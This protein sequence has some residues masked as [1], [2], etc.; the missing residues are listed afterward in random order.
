MATGA[1]IARILTQYSD[2]GSKAAQKDIAR[3]TKKFDDFGK[4]ARKSFA[5]AI[6]ATAAL[7]VK[8]GTDAV[9]AAIDDAKSQVVLANALKSVTD[10]SGKLN[11]Q[12]ESY[13]KTTMFRVNVADEQLRA[14]LATLIISTGDLTK[15]EK[16]QTIALDVA[17]ATG[18]DLSAVTVAMTKANEGNVDALKR[19]SPELSG[20]IYKGMKAEDAFALLGVTY[21]GTAEALADL[22]P[23]T[24][25]RLAYGETLETLGTALLPVI[26]EFAE[27][28]ISDVI[29][30]VDE[31]V[32]ANGDKLQTAIRD[33]ADGIIYF[34]GVFKDLA[35]FLS[36]NRV[37]ITVALNLFAIGRGAK[38]A[39][40]FLT[41]I[42]ELI[43]SGIKYFKSFGKATDN[44]KKKFFDL[45]KTDK[46]G[47]FGRFVH[48]LG[49]GIEGISKFLGG[50]V[51]LGAAGIAVTKAFKSLF[52]IEEKRKDQLFD[53]T[54][55]TYGGAA[56]EKYKA[57]VVAAAAKK[58]AAA[59]AIAAAASK[60]AAAQEAKDAA[61]QAKVDSRV[62]AIR[63]SLNITKDSAL[64]K[65]TDLIS[66]TAAA[67]FLAKQGVIAK[68]ELAKIDRL[69]EENLLLSARDTLIKRYADIQEKLAD[70]KLET[71]EIEELSKKWG[72]SGAAVVAYIHLVKSVEDQVISTEEI[73]TL[74]DLWNTSEY[75]A[76]KF[77][78]TYMRIQDGL[79]DSNEVFALIKAGFF[80]TEREARTYADI[81]STVHDG[82]ANDED[83]QKVMDKWDLTKE[84]L[85]QYILKMGADFDYE[86]KL[87]YPITQL[88][89]KWDA[90]SGA[91]QRYLDKLNS[92]KSFDYNKLGPSGTPII[93]PKPGDPT[94]TPKAGDPATGDDSIAKRAAASAAAAAAYAAAKARGDMDAAAKA[95]AGVNPSALAAGE[96]GAIGAASI[97]SQLRA[98]EAA[99][100]TAT[101]QGNTLTRFR[102]KE[103][104]DL[105][106]SLAASSQLDADERSK[107]R[108]MT[109][110]NASSI[111]GDTSG[112]AKSLNVTVNISGN[113]TTEQD[114]VT[115]IRNGL[116]NSQY[117]GDAITLQAI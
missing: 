106:A 98:A 90:A 31:W 87:L 107:F 64:D 111:S 52:G 21:A 14:S 82:I 95:A 27:Y 1:V 108:S 65:E 15:A 68:E 71:K 110:A 114:L 37:L 75:E 112:N 45:V 29:P 81:V 91:L 13:I 28:I 109:M 16:L 97:A 67:N 26:K 32:A 73:K 35:K 62:L 84:K 76:Q 104:E 85:N 89:I 5:L 58:T 23:L 92:A 30:A 77:L 83:F 69:K 54:K 43:G 79:L 44:L 24:K 33:I 99:L 102:A 101:A 53:I 93:T 3:L 56:A 38:I 94:V 61:Y 60:K 63:K 46:D 4:R 96:S 39:G 117:N 105:A 51:A 50:F 115:S 113:V 72:I 49:T 70:Q 86:G 42:D 18:K 11:A 34:S 59:Q 36:D 47:S 78:E 103:A 8:I 2:K 19:L 48:L 40:K 10:A 88:A 80:E 20:L 100:A 17:G 41:K 25:L 55:Q 66:L 22:D 57:E 74:A 6:T 12:A 7:S 9:Q 116:L